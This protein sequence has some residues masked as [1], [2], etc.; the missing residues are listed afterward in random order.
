MD[1]IPL[2][3]LFGTLALL[4]VLSAFFSGSETGLMTLNRYRLRHLAKTGHR[5]ARRASS[6]LERPDRLIGVILLGNNL[7]N[8]AASAVATVIGIRLYGD[9]G[10]L[11]ATMALTVLILIFSE[12]TPKT[13]A[14]LHPERIAFPASF[15]YGPLLRLFSPVVAVINLIA[16]GI[17]RLFKVSPEDAAAH[18]LS[19]EELRTVVA[20]AGAMIPRR[21]QQMLLSILDLENSTVEDIMVPRNEI[22]GIDMA[23]DWAAILAQLVHNQHTRLPLYDGSIDDLRGIV[24]L[25]RVLALQADNNLT[26]ENMLA[27][28]KEPY[29]VPENTPLTQQLLNFQTQRRRIGF[30][31]DEY[32]DLQGLIT[33][34]DILEEIVGEFTTDPATRL[35]NVR[36][37]PDGSFLVDGTASVR[38]LN[39]AMGWTLPTDGPKT[40]NGVVLEHLET[41]PQAGVSMKLAGYAIEITATQANVVKTVT[42]RPL[43]AAARPRH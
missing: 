23:Q 36:Q 30:V 19:T 42:V 22:V 12:V 14:A 33:L 9:I 5:G 27:L 18:S 11:G 8:I 2:P 32:G 26:K 35:K 43:P 37:Q 24:H 6:L 3:I 41:I 15:V 31:V 40:I 4:L 28:A 21:H 1:Q 13:L 10:V 29:F 34:E 20:E 16:N 7:V 39:R 38:S 25:R 17:L